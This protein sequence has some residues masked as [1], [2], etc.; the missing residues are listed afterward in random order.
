MQSYITP[1]VRPATYIASVILFDE[2]DDPITSISYPAKSITKFRC[3]E[4]GGL[5][6]PKANLR[7]LTGCPEQG[8]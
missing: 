5:V 3:I 1:P 6:L 4:G 7:C 8:F 2:N